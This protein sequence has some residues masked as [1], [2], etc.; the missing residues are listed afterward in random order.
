MAIAEVYITFK[1]KKQAEKIVFTLL[2]EKLVACANIFPASSVYPWKNKLKRGKEFV[3]MCKTKH[4]LV[5]AVEARV[6]A[7]HSYDIP[8]ILSWAVEANREFENWVFEST[9]NMY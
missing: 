8:C 9:S 7:L 5:N 1:G 2:K 6:K 3:A 4:A